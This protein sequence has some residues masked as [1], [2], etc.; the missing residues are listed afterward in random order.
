MDDNN[1]KNPFI[2]DEVLVDGTEEDE[3]ID[4]SWGGSSTS[5]VVDDYEWQPSSPPFRS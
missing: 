2:D 1:P 5:F 4:M 3:V